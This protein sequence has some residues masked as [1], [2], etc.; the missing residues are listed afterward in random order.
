MS[1]A[2]RA[3]ICFRTLFCLT[4]WHLLDAF[5]YTLFSDEYIIGECAQKPITS[6]A[7][8]FWCMHALSFN[9]IGVLW[10]DTDIIQQSAV[11]IERASEFHVR[12]IYRIVSANSRCCDGKHSDPWDWVVIDTLS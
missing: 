5:V 10:M 11:L 7:F 12:Y 6:A 8:F 3:T 9:C 4:V 1:K 2:A